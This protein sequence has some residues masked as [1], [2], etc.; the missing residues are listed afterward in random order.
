MHSWIK[1]DDIRVGDVVLQSL[2]GHPDLLF[3]DRVIAVDHTSSKAWVWV[4]DTDEAENT[5]RFRK[6]S[7]VTVIRGL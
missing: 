3:A 7:T 4:N 2:N 5:L 6:G 1:A